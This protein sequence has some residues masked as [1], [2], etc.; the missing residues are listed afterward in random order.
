MAIEDQLDGELCTV[1]NKIASMPQQSL[2]R[3]MLLRARQ[4]IDY[5]LGEEAQPGPAQE[6]PAADA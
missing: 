5:V 6:L 3:A 4:R 2:A 1:L